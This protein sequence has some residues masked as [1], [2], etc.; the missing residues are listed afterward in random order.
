VPFDP[1]TGCD[2]A[3]GWIPNGYGGCIQ[4][5]AGSGSLPNPTEGQCAPNFYYHPHYRCCLPYPEGAD[6]GNYN[7]STGQCVDVQEC[8]GNH[9]LDQDTN[10]CVPKSQ[11]CCDFG[12]YWNSNV[13]ECVTWYLDAPEG[14]EPCTMWEEWNGSECVP[15]GIEMDQPVC[16]TATLTAPDCSTDCPP[17]STLNPETGKCICACGFVLN[18][19][20]V[21]AKKPCNSFDGKNSCLKNCCS[22]VT[23]LTSAPYCQ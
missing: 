2:T 20:G 7:P 11:D 4:V 13:K 22:W 6:L 17:N 9:M 12:Q 1:Q 5:P 21:C 8:P 3:H 15:I 10:C 16:E 23:P 19:N 18:D 14:E